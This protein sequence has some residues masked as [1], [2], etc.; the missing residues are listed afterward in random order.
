MSDPVIDIRVTAN[1]E[2]ADVALKKVGE[3]AKSSLGKGSPLET[4][5]I[6]GGNSVQKVGDRFVTVTKHSTEYRDANLR[7]VKAQEALNN[8]T[9]TGVARDIEVEAAK[10]RVAKASEHFTEVQ[11]KENKVLQ[12]TK[13]GMTAVGQGT[14]GLFAAFSGL[15]LYG[16]SVAVAF[17]ALGLASTKVLEEFNNQKAANLALNQAMQDAGEKIT[18][19][20]TQSLRDAQTAGENLGFEQSQTTQSLANLTLAGL[21]QKQTLAQLPLIMDLARAKGLSLAD[22]TEVII[23]GING[24]TRGLKDYNIAGLL[25]L[26][27]TASMANAATTLAKDHAA[28]GTAFDAVTAAEKRYGDGSKQ[29]TAAYAKYEAAMAKVNAEQEKLN[30][31]QNLAYVRAHNLSIMHEEL[32]KKV[33]GQAVAATHS[34]GVEWQIISARFNDFAGQA[35]PKI[36]AGV[37]TM[38]Q[39]IGV[40]I[41]WLAKNVFPV[42]GE[43]VSVISSDIKAVA[44]IFIGAFKV[45]VTIVSTYVKIVVGI[46]KVEFAI[47]SGI[48]TTVVHLI[49]GIANVVRGAFSVIGTVIT[50]ALAGPKAIIDGLITGINWIIGLIDAIKIPKI[51]VGPVTLFAGWNGLQL[52]KIPMLYEGGIAL[53]SSGGSLAIVGDKGQDE[54]I[55]PLPQNWRSGG[56]Q[57]QG[58]QKNVTINQYITTQAN[59]DRITRTLLT[60]L[61]TA[62]VGRI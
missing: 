36:E 3:T 51:Q 37:A 16:G 15:S 17:S 29:V 14:E 21:S 56:A 28:A 31:T 25:T 41:N 52:P 7:L 30:T 33:G 49:G 48:I 59:P 50:V 45:I 62:G 2:Q 34:L 18:P 60:G 11:N 38:L 53:G 35:I 12:G 9:A 61:R 54:A 32:S 57:G 47:I 55:V 5:S 4:A 8:I 44:P 23:K 40:G 39:G 58:Q 1:T 10:L 43:I 46:F 6:Q 26:P 20:W 13:K 27:T 22:A 24:Q 19:Q 42:I